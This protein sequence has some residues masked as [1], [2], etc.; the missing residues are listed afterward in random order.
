MS[1]TAQVAPL[2]VMPAGTQ[3]TSVAPA[4]RGKLPAPLRAKQ[5]SVS[6]PPVWTTTAGLT[7]MLPAS[8]PLPVPVMVVELSVPTAGWSLSCPPSSRGRSG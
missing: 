4:A 8:V 3:M 5:P 6:V 7:V 2:A 1:C